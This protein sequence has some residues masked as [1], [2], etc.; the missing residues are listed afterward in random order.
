MRL[1]S[2]QT[3]KNPRDVPF[4]LA[5]YSWYFASKFGLRI[6]T[7]Y[8]KLN[9]QWQVHHVQLK[10]PLLHWLMVDQGF[11]A[12]RRLNI[13]YCDVPYSFFILC[14]QVWFH[15]P[16]IMLKT[17][18]IRA[19]PSC[20]TERPVLAQGGSRLWSRQTVKNPL[21]RCTLFFSFLFLILCIHVWFDDPNNV[22]FKALHIRKKQTTVINPIVSLSICDTLY[23]S[24][25]W[26]S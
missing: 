25:V 20:S 18:W 1:W 7:T 22:V 5:F 4:S 6:L 11:E 9:G 24:S 13:H 15:N 21:F 3:V 19:S 23:V 26:W 10:G 12:V 14:I 17:Q 2:R 8:W 16:N